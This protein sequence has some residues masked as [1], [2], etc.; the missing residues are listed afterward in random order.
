M[1]NPNV[2]GPAY[3]EEPVAFELLKL[4]VQ[5]AWADHKLHRDEIETMLHLAD[6][7]LPS[8]ERLAEVEAW[9]EGREPL[10]APNLAVLREHPED[11]L[12][13]VKRVLLSDGEIPPEER[14]MYTKLERLLLSKKTADG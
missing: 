12:L 6:A 5:V 1:S 14:T 8:D 2:R 11:V 7:L 3:L 4:L 13:E 10:P 9:L